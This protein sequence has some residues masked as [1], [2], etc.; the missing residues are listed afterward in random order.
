MNHQEIITKFYTAFKQRDWKTMHGYYHKDITFYDPAFRHLAGTDVLA[1]WHMLC[2]NAKDFKL[3]FKNV[4]ASERKGSCDWQASYTFS[5]TGRTVHNSI[6][7]NFIFKD[8]LIVDHK[9]EF[10]L[11]RWSRMALGLSGTLLGWSSI[12]QKKINQNALKSLEK[13]KLEHGY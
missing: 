3:T 5:K 12:L 6:T 8:G 7:A 11:W 4:H 9:D 10:D 13:F 2:L 1:M